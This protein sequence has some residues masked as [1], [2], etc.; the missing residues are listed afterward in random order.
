[1]WGGQVPSLWRAAEACRRR[2]C[3]VPGS[4]ALLTRRVRVCACVCVRVCVCACVCVCVCVC[5]GL[6]FS[7]EVTSDSLR[8]H[9]L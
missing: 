1:M 3:W 9:G 2:E 5:G 4:G 7:R 8:P 6:L